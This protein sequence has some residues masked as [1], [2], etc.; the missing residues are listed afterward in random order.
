[1]SG[2]LRNATQVHG[3]DRQR[4]ETVRERLQTG[5]L[6]AY[7]LFQFINARYRRITV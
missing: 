7:G 3:R 2:G 6:I 5:H 4:V 1:M